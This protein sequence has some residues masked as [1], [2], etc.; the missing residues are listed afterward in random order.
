LQFPQ[1]GDAEHGNNDRMLLGVHPWD[2]H[3]S[4]EPGEWKAGNNLQ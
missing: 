2:E 4:V 1:H 3:K